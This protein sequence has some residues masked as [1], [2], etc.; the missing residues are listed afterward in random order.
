MRTTPS[1]KGITLRSV[2]LLSVISLTVATLLA[3]WSFGVRRACLLKKESALASQIDNV[4]VKILPREYLVF[5]GGVLSAA[6]REKLKYEIDALALDQGAK[7]ARAERAKLEL[8][9]G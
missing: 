5:S 6:G 7:F 9:R 8:C 3:G 2:A 4:E 1:T